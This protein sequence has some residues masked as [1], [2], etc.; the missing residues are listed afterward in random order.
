MPGIDLRILC[1]NL[2]GNVTDDEIDYSFR[3]AQALG[4]SAIYIQFHGDDCQTR[5]PFRR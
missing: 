3:M 4:A 2:N 5:C 1:Y